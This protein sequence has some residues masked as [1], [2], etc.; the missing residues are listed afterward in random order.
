MNLQGVLSALAQP[1][2][3]VGWKI[4]ATNKDKTKGMVVAYIDARD[5]AAR[6]DEVGVEWGDRYNVMQM[7]ERPRP[8]GTAAYWVVECAL[9]INAVV[10]CDVGTGEG[11]EAEK[12]AYSDAFKRAA[13]KFGVGRYLYSLPSVWMPVE[14]RQLS[15]E[16]IDKLN[17]AYRRKFLNAS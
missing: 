10:R 2:Q 13:V 8:S 6:L 12:S 15:Q 17:A 11:E 5:V 14:D 1:F 16:S 4:Q 7:G 9:E 3:E